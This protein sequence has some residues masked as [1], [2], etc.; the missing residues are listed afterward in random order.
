M[1]NTNIIHI[2]NSKKYLKIISPHHK[3]QQTTVNNIDYNVMY[4]LY[5]GIKKKTYWCSAA[6]TPFAIAQ[7]K[8]LKM[9]QRLTKSAQNEQSFEQFLYLLTPKK[10]ILLF[11]HKKKHNKRLNR[12][13][14][15]II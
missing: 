9:A 5:S 10:R 11:A 13:I 2:S 4:W 6:Y 14:L 12:N 7:I 8:S 15:S 3:K 1:E